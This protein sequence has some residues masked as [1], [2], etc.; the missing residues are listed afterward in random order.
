VSDQVVGVVARLDV[1]FGQPY[2][3][4]GFL[5][6]DNLNMENILHHI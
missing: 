6:K 1:I 3:E 2:D 4:Y 5:S